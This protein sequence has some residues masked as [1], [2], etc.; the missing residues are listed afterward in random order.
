[1]LLVLDHTD[2]VYS[3]ESP[4]AI[5]YKN[6]QKSL[7]CFSHLAPLNLFFLLNGRVKKGG[8]GTMPPYTLLTA[9]HLFRDKTIIGKES[10]I[11]FS[12]VDK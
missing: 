4:L 1:M 2:L 10:T 9:L 3:P 6:Y 5:N 8:H 11:G 7:A 12:A